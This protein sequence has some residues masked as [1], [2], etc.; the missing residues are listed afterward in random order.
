MPLRQGASRPPMTGSCGQ[1]LPSG[2]DRRHGHSVL[3]SLPG[4]KGA[5]GDLFLHALDLDLALLREGHVQR[6]AGGRVSEDLGGPNLE[7]LIH[8]DTLAGSAVDV[9]LAALDEDDVAAPVQVRDLGDN[10]GHR[11]V[12]GLLHGRA[13]V[14]LLEGAH[15]AAEV[16]IRK[17][18]GETPT[19]HLPQ[20]FLGRHDLACRRIDDVNLRIDFRGVAA[21]PKSNA[22]KTHPSVLARGRLE[23]GDDTL[24]EELRRG[25]RAGHGSLVA[26]GHTTALGEILL[27][28]RGVAHILLPKHNKLSGLL[29]GVG[30]HLAPGVGQIELAIVTGVIL[31]LGHHDAETEAARGSI[32]RSGGRTVCEGQRGQ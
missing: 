2:R 13:D 8:G 1:P 6:L 12:N 16:A 18:H 29:E 3:K 5:N 20:H 17:A 25:H 9:D 22:A 30:E 32:R 27:L 23:I 15:V 4:D 26:T 11:I 19:L 21:H 14:G 28:H 7:D 31:E 24:H 10:K